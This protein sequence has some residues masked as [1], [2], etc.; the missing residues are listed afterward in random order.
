MSLKNFS[1]SILLVHISFIF[2]AVG[3][4]CTALLSR[5]GSLHLFPGETT[6]SYVLDDSRVAPLPFTITLIDFDIEFYPDS[7]LPKDYL[8][9]IHTSKGDTIQIS[10][11]H[12]GH[13]PGGFR[14]YQTSYDD[15]GGTRLTV[16]HDPIGTSIVYFGFLLFFI[17]ATGDLFNRLHRKVTRRAT[18]YAL[19]V[20]AISLAIFA[21]CLN[22]SRPGTLPVL[23]TWWM[24]V[25]VG[26][27][28]AGYVVLISTLPLA[29]MSLAWKKEGE[30]LLS[31]AVSL[32]APG[33]YLLGFGIILGAMWANVSWGRYWGWDPKETWA[34]ITFIVYSIPLHLSTRT[35]SID[36]RTRVRPYTPTRLFSIFLI[37]GALSIAMTYLGVN[38]LPSLHSYL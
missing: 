26:F 35:F 8:S 29:A 34:L 38:Y 16:S 33:V 12:I 7:E 13:L 10:M 14:L 30:R 5:H 28:A 15:Y 2:I 31:T 36:G 37:L 18:L 20:A 3:G 25:H 21:F 9:T 6:A 1:K 23:A 24:P 11:N 32:T 17:G 27:C 4:I 19:A 22:P